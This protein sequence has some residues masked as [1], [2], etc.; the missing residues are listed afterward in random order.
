MRLFHIQTKKNSLTASPSNLEVEDSLKTLCGNN[1][2]L[3]EAMS[4]FLLLDPRSQE[5]M[6]GNVP[7]I[8]ERGMKDLESG[9]KIRARVSFEIAARQALYHQDRQS[10]ERALK[11]AD[12]ASDGEELRFQLHQ[13]VLS[14][15]DKTFTIA[16]QFY[17]HMTIERIEEK[18][19]SENKAVEVDPIL[20]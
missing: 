12:Q 1:E 3:Y 9:V 5:Q 7:R 2:Q 17:K 6:V 11:L 8:L 10:F 20:A 14:N 16:D 18:K 4:N 15:L 19:T 13:A